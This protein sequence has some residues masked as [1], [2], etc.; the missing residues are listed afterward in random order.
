MRRQAVRRTLVLM[1]DRP[2][3]RGRGDTLDLW[4]ESGGPEWVGIG[5]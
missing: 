4:G 2:E 5:A 3:T 1:E